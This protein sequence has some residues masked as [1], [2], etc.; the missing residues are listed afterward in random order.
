MSK[1]K[2]EVDTSTC[3]GCGKV[4]DDAD[5]AEIQDY[6]SRTEPG[7]MIPSGE[8]PVENCGAL[9]Y[10]NTVHARTVHVA[11]DMAKLIVDMIEAGNL[12]P[13]KMRAFGV[14][15]RAIRAQVE[16]R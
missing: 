16:G 1:K 12:T 7:Y 10:P 4:Y 3:D 5:L 13:T 2:I 8:C 6:H 15:A 11:E 14:R 9:C